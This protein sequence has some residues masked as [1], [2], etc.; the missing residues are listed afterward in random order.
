MHATAGDVY[1]D[2]LK[3]VAGSV[4][5]VGTNLLQDGD[6]ESPLSGLWTLS[7]NMT[8]SVISTDVKHSGNASLHVIATSAGDTLSQAIW[9]TTAPIVT[10]GTYTLSYWYLPSTNST[11]LLIR[12][13]GSSPNNGQV[14]SL[15]SVQPF[16]AITTT[17][18][19]G[20]A[21]SV[22]MTLPPFPPLW[23]NEVQA[24]NLT[25]ITN[26]TGRHV[27]WFELFNPTTN[28]VSLSGL[29]LSTNYDNLTA[30]TFPAGSMINPGEF[31]V[32]FA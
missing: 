22:L 14:Y 25:G 20:A 10:N 28:S 26:S 11:Q 8:N 1:L 13:S 30:W 3:L 24:D 23:I 7:S 15:Q 27:P 18:T 2:D 4:P 16:S 19:P 31:K 5:E 29:Y 21:N 12:L 6:F 9:E 17:Y 32:I